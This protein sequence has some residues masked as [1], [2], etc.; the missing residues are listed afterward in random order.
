MNPLAS[1]PWPT[2]QNTTAKPKWNGDHFDLDNQSVRVLTYAAEESHWSDQLTSLHEDTAGPDHPIDVASRELAVLSMAKLTKE[3]PI[4]L[5]VGC[6][7]GYILQDLQE[8]F[9]AASLIGADY[10]FGPLKG[11]ASRMP[12]IPIMQFDLRSCPLPDECVDGITCLN[13]LEHIDDHE[14]AMEEIYRIL[15]PGGIAHVEVPAGPGLFDIYDEYL[16][17]H[18]RY[19]MKD[20]VIMAKQDGFNIFRKTHLGAF[21]YLPFALVKLRNKRKLKWSNSAK[22]KFVTQQIQNTGASSIFKILVWAE[23]RLGKLISFPLGIRCVI[24][25]QK[26]IS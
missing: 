24:T 12:N 6:S 21:V 14:A 20:L 3:S 18:R 22:E 23:S 5:D 15:K 8:E 7:S 17:H 11:L 2:P 16:M 9:P 26:P 13:V 25:L 4:L 1:F 10:I 19:R